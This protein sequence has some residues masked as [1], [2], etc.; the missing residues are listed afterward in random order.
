DAV[1]PQAST[2]IVRA[3]LAFVLFADRVLERVFL[4]GRPLA[5][6]RFDAV[7]LDGRQHACGLLAAH[8]ADARIGPHPQE[9]RAIRTA[10]HRVVAGA[11]AAANHHGEL[12]HVRAGHG[13]DHLGAVLG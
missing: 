9:A 12:R 10:A 11:E 7:A 5:A 6:A 2:G 13:R 3:A 4:F 8:H 1:V